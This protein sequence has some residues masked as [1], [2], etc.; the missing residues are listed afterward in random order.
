MAQDIIGSKMPA[1]N[2]YGQNGFPGASSDLPGQATKSGF[3]PACDVVAATAAS[4]GGRDGAYLGGRS[5]KAAPR[6]ASRGGTVLG[7]QTRDVG[8]SDVKP[9][10]G[11]LTR[12][13]RNR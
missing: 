3:L 4:V 2:G 1:L 6:A 5:G 8:V 11:M 13:P 12:S 10:Y 9:S 7:P